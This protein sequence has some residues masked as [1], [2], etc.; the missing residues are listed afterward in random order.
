[1]PMIKPEKGLIK[2]V[3]KQTIHN[4]EYSV[5]TQ[6]EV[7]FLFNPTELSFSKSNTWNIPGVPKHGEAKPIEFGGGDPRTVTL[8]LL[9]DTYEA[10]DKM[11]EAAGKSAP[12]VPKDVREYTDKLVEMMQPQEGLGP[13]EGGWPPQ[14]E[15]IW[16]HLKK[17]KAWS[18]SAYITSLTQK[19]V[20][21]LPD[22]M[23]VR[24]IC[25]VALKQA[26]FERLAPQNPTSGGRGNERT[27]LVQPGERLDFI[28]YQ[29]YGDSTL[30][31]V[32]AD[33]NGLNSLRDL[34]V[35]QRLAIP[36]LR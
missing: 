31:R 22:G 17:G 35:G 23:P 28:A 9:F 16:G 13:D 27:R 25:T 7:P 1:M 21:F 20:L 24:A 26:V 19:F 11:L 34:P 14:V 8:E 6:I 12:N 3:A 29:E 33:A 15:V 32:I 36:T 30:W 18:F 4:Q 10:H 5:P 2:T